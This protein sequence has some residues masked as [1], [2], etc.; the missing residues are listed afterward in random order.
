MKILVLSS[1]NDH[2]YND[3]KIISEGLQLYIGRI[4]HT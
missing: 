4:E 2:W 3:N 1:F